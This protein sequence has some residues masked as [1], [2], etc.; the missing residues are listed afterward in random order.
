M[1][2]VLQCL[3][4]TEPLLSYCLQ[5]DLEHDLNTSVTS[6]M[7]GALMKGKQTPNFKN[8]DYEI[9]CV[10]FRIHKFNAKNVAYARRSIDC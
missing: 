4:N 3:S 5:I 1:N 8:H 2:S 6:V 9:D 7:K 10:F